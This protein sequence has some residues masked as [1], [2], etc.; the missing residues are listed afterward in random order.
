[1]MQI[2]DAVTVSHL[3]VAV[4]GMSATLKAEKPKHRLVVILCGEV[5]NE[6]TPLELAPVVVNFLYEMGWTHP[7]LKPTP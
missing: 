2:G 5:P 6:T 3:P 4:P 1:M 7:E